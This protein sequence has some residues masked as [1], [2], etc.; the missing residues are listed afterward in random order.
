[1]IA[2]GWH[3]ASA[4]LLLYQAAKRMRQ[5]FICHLVILDSFYGGPYNPWLGVWQPISLFRC[6]HA[7]FSLLIPAVESLARS[8]PLS[9]LWDRQKYGQRQKIAVKI[10]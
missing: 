4:R 8:F 1:M 5:V 7:R 9:E 2:P 10:L 3:Y 6:T